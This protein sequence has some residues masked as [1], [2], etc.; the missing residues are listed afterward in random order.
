MFVPCSKTRITISYVAK[1]VT[2]CSKT[3][4]LFA[5]LL[6]SFNEKILLPADYHLTNEIKKALAISKVCE[7]HQLTKKKTFDIKN[8]EKVTLVLKK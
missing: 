2:H 1:R 7:E 6:M 8:Y 5:E 3:Q 4:R